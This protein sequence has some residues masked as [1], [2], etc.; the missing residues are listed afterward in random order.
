ML[1][2]L[3]GEAT[4]IPTTEIHC[5]LIYLFLIHACAHSTTF[6]L[7]G[8]GKPVQSSEDDIGEA[9]GD[10]NGDDVKC[11]KGVHE[12]AQDDEEYKPEISRQKVRNLISDNWY[13]VRTIFLFCLINRLKKMYADYYN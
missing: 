2:E 5:G 13:I 9:E 1:T 12:V 3:G 6:L 11:Q 4:V 10:G 8:V 7:E